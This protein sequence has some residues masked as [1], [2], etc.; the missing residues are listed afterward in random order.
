MFFNFLRCLNVNGFTYYHFAFGHLINI[1]IPFAC[2]D[3]IFGAAVNIKQFLRYQSLNNWRKQEQ[4]HTSNKCCNFAE[5]IVAFPDAFSFD[6][7]FNEFDFKFF[8]NPFDFNA[9]E[10]SSNK[11]TRTNKAL[12]HE[13]MSSVNLEQNVSSN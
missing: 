5:N 9:Q 10:Y 7:N 11:T 8:F 4:P 6:F 12:P 13:N 3:F 2:W 1:K